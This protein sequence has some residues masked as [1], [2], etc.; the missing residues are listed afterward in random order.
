MRKLNNFILI[1]G[2]PEFFIA[3]LNRTTSIS[4]IFIKLSRLKNPSNEYF[5]IFKVY[6]YGDR[7]K[8]WKEYIKGGEKIEKN[9]ANKFNLNTP[10]KSQK[11][12]RK[13]FKNYGEYLN[14]ELK[15][16]DDKLKKKYNIDEDFITKLVIEATENKWSKK[17]Y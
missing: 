5:K 3:K 4:R 2:S 7:I 13:R 1:Y 12:A 10:V 16:F 9:V 6:N 15:K 17:Y 14:K 11:D 8:I